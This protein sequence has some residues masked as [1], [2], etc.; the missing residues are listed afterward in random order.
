MNRIPL[1]AWILW[2]AVSV[3]LS[4][5]VLPAIANGSPGSPVL[6]GMIWFIFYVESRKKGFGTEDRTIYRIL[7]HLSM[8]GA[9]EGDTDNGFDPNFEASLDLPNVRKFGPLAFPRKLWDTWVFLILVSIL[10]G[11]EKVALAWMNQEV[12]QPEL[13]DFGYVAESVGLV[14]SAMAF[15]AR[16]NLGHRNW[17]VRRKKFD[18]ICQFKGLDH[19]ERSRAWR[20]CLADGLVT[21]DD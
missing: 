7:C 10:V 13:Y 2:I 4:V 3:A 1:T 20:E 15:W 12:F 19:M 14:V 5:Y 11:A 6:A 8:R 9:R 18:E 21:N 16:Y 17:K